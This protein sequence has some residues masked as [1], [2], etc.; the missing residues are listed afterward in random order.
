MSLLTEHLYLLN[1]IFPPFVNHQKTA[2]KL[3]KIYNCL[4]GKQLLEILKYIHQVIDES[5]NVYY[6]GSTLLLKKVILKRLFHLN[7]SLQIGRASCRE[8]VMVRVGDVL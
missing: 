4:I 8:R 6:F 1:Y 2:Y 5:S 7:Y 3:L